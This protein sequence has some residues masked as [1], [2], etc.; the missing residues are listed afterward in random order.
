MA[1]DPQRVVLSIQCWH[2][3]TLAV[4][5][6]SLYAVGEVRWVVLGGAA[7]LPFSIGVP[8][9]PPHFANSLES[10]TSR[11][12]RGKYRLL[13]NLELSS[14]E[15]STCAPLW[16][17]ARIRG[18]RALLL[19]LDY[20]GMISLWAQGQMSQWGCGKLIGGCSWPGPSKFRSKRS[21]D[22]HPQ[23]KGDSG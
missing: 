9:P 12:F 4:P 6:F 17:Q 3:A 19:V 15:S 1:G 8:P 14:F 20:D 13:K 23:R 18:P 21:L 2:S 11:L 5:I 7:G 16:F 10:S 22:G